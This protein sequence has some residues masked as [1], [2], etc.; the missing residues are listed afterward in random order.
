MVLRLGI[1]GYYIM[2]TCVTLLKLCNLF[3][4]QFLHL[5]DDL[6]NTYLTR[7]LGVFNNIKSLRLC[8]LDQRALTHCG[9]VSL[10]IQGS[11][12]Q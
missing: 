9:F 3:L 8:A 12:T 10:P 7:L 5:S 1:I 11:L 6:E 2:A 4:P